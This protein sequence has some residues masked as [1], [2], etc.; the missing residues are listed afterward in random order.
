M[1]QPENIDNL[2]V[3]AQINFSNAARIITMRGAPKLTESELFEAEQE[4][5]NAVAHMKAA[6]RQAQLPQPDDSLEWGA[7]GTRAAGMVREPGGA[8]RNPTKNELSEHTPN[9]DVP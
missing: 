5:D 8:W 9:D 7:D 1:N 4:L 3:H 2:L 6:I